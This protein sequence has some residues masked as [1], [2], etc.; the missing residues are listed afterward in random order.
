MAN[1]GIQWNKLWKL[2]VHEKLKMMLWRIGLDILPTNKNFVQRVGRG[3]PMC[4]LCLVEE[5]SI[6]HLFSSALPLELCGLV[7][8][9]DYILNVFLFT[10]VPTLLIW[11]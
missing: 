7:K 6:P 11:F 2:P 8:V 5:E 1:T 3:D 9:W 4:P 10:L